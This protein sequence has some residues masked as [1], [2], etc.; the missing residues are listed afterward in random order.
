MT[1]FLKKF[2]KLQPFTAHDMNTHTNLRMPAYTR[3]FECKLCTHSWPSN[4]AVQNFT[5]SNGAL[6]THTFSQLCNLKTHVESVHGLKTFQCYI[7]MQE[8]SSVVNLDNHIKT[9]HA[10]V[11]SLYHGGCD[12]GMHGDMVCHQE[13]KMHPKAVEQ[14]QTSLPVF[15]KTR[16]L[17]WPVRKVAKPEIVTRKLTE[18]E[19]MI[20]DHAIFMA[21]IN[22]EIKQSLQI[23]KEA[24][25]KTNEAIVKINSIME[26]LAVANQAIA[27]L[28]AI[29][30]VQGIE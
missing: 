27:K 26:A 30:S 1:C 6:E 29:T 24:N 23:T 15:K 11:Y 22:E 25:I 20:K 3:M 7:C 28:S 5:P 18:M 19:Q 21:K 4:S 9:T 12:T 10:E 2:T 8:L 17:K 14:R 13:S 16:T